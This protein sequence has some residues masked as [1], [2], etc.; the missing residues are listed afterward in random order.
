MRLHYCDDD[1]DGARIQKKEGPGTRTWALII[2]SEPFLLVYT[3][4]SDLGAEQSA[5]TPIVPCSGLF[6]HMS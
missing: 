5:D 6:L 2:G 4:P 3:Y 1:G